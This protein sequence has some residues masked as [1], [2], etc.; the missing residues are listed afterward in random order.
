MNCSH[1]S[2]PFLIVT[3]SLTLWADAPR[4]SVPAIFT[5]N[6]R[7]LFQGDSITDGNRGRTS[8]P[9]HILGH[10]YAFL[11]AAKFGGEMPVLNLDFVNRGISGNT[12][13]NLKERWQADTLDLKPDVL[14]I[15]IGVNDQ[16]SQIPMDE[17]EQTYDELLAQT[18]QS[19]PNVKLV[20]CEPFGLPV[21][22]VK[23]NWNNWSH[24][25]KQRTV[26]V[27][28][29]AQKYD[30]AVVHFQMAFDQA[31]EEAPAEYWIWDGI[32]PTYRGH[33]RMAQ[34]WE[35]AVLARWPQLQLIPQD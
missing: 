31:V 18:R 32:H 35:R 13:R 26:I 7:I 6:S 29:L 34:E 25:L 20:L 4:T 11:I 12:I 16:D 21:G 14:S 8:D 10:G 5:P 15:L 2:A 3:L 1:F 23:S 17:F 19:L 28:R 30:A 33:Q 9:N 22:G 24:G 27:E